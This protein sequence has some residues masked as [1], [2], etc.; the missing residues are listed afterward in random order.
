MAD[1]TVRLAAEAEA[2]LQGIYET[3]LAQR[4]SDGADGADALLDSLIA[5]IET[6][7]LFPLRGPV[8]SELAALGIAAWRQLSLPPYRVIYAVEAGPEAQV[9]TIALVADSRR[10]FR[11]LLQNRL[12]APRC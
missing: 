7:A 2:D 12:L 9:V 1:I 8:P 10:D 11:T 6:L 3:R 4:G 5:L